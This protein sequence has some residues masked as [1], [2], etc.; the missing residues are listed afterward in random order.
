MYCGQSSQPSCEVQCFEACI[1]CKACCKKQKVKFEVP[2][3]NKNVAVEASLSGGNFPI[4]T[5]STTVI[6]NSV[7]LNQTCYKP[8][9]G[10]SRDPCCCKKKS[11]HRRDG[12]GCGR[13][14]CGGG[15][16]QPFCPPFPGWGQFYDSTTGIATVPQGGAGRYI[17]FAS[18]SSDSANTV[19][20][21][22]QV[23]GTAVA[24]DTLGGATGRTKVSLAGFYLLSPSQQVKVVAR[25]DTGA[26]NI[27][28]GADSNIK[29]VRIG[30]C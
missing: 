13:G 26:S 10:C 6:F 29:F 16:Y 28:A 15:C 18:V 12:C 11:H 24:S 9:Q 4:T 2:I 30:Y 14:G 1:K 25:D 22:I 21:E 27:L 5:A 3:Q 7:Q 8:C 20:V 17:L 23:N 19:T